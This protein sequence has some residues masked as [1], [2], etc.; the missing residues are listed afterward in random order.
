MNSTCRWFWSG[1]F[2]QRFNSPTRKKL[3]TFGTLPPPYT[4]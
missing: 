1:C 2:H 3:S 4:S